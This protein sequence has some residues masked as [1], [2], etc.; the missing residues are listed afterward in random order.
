MT[1]LLTLQQTLGVSFNDPSLLET[2]LIHSSYVNENPDMGLVSN[3]RLEFLGDAVLGLIVAEKLYH[4]HP[5]CSEGEMTR[6]RAALI[7]Q[8]TLFKIAENINLGGYLYLGKGEESSG[9]RNK[10]L[11]LAGATEAVIAAIFLDQGIAVAGD[12]VLSLL[13]K[14]MREV[15]SR[16]ATHDYKSQLQHLVQLN[17]QQ[18]PAY[19]VIKIEGPDHNRKFT[20]TVSAGNTVLGQGTGKS[21]K[22]AETSAARSALKNLLG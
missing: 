2:A 1:N 20:V 10:P 16:G 15:I 7:R 12:L 22:L 6:I 14:E 13:D 17:Q 8:K 18:P 3:K 21:K 4:D 11:N 19:R 5:G 9:G